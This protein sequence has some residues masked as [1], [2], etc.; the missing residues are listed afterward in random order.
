M[1]CVPHKLLVVIRVLC[2]IWVLG[3]HFDMLLVMMVM[4]MTM[5]TG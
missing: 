2:V 1:S 4:M 5:M 3:V